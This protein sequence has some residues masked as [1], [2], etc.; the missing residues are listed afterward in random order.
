MW[1]TWRTGQRAGPCVL[2]ACCV[3]SLG[4]GGDAGDFAPSGSCPCGRQSAATISA[5]PMY[6]PGAIS[7]APRGV[8]IGP[9]PPVIPPPGTL[10]LTYQRQSWLIPANKHPRIGMLD[11]RAPAGATSVRVFTTYQFRE[12]DEIEGF[13]DL[14]DPCVWHFETKPLLPGIPHVYRVESQGPTVNDWRMVR[15]IRGRRVTLEF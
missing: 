6:L 9:L 11:V 15:L 2:L 8:Y 1:K 13:Q 5:A 10:G 3:L 4:R 7:V 12:E 14:E